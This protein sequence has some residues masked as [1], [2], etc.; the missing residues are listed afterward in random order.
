MIAPDS[1]HLP[2]GER[3]R[4]HLLRHIDHVT[5]VGLEVGA[6]NRPTVSPQDGKI[7]FADFTS[8]E[9]LRNRYRNVPSVQEG[10]IVGVDF[11]WSGSRLADLVGEVRFD[12]VI[13]SH[14][15]EHIPNPIYWLEQIAE[16]LNPGGLLSLV[17]PDKRFTFDRARPLAILADIVG[18]YVEGATKPTSSQIFSHCSSHLQVDPIVAW[19]DPEGALNLEFPAVHTN[20]EAFD[21]THQVWTSGQYFDVHC[22]PM[23]PAS[24]L[25]I[26]HGLCAIV[27]FPFEIVAFT[28]SQVNEIDFFATLRRQDMTLCEDERLRR[29]YSA[30][31]EARQ[32]LRGTVGRE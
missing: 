9:D 16:C 15:I 28:D 10:D 25:D 23:T 8:T 4:A 19:S 27:K 21:M 26:I 29:Q 11:V 14:V 2:A 5:M 30:I 32:K 18:A 3:R 20:K 13:A 31:E 12:Y 24:F 6:L 7:Y 1:L 17:I 22:W